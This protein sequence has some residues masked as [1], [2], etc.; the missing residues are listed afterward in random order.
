MK[1]KAV[2]LLLILSSTVFARPSFMQKKISVGSKKVV[3]EIADDEEKR[4][5]GLMKVTKLERDHG[6]LFI[7]ERE[8]PLSFWMKDTPI[9]LSIGFF[10]S[11]KMLVQI[12]EMKTAS[13]V[14]QNLPVYKSKVPCQYALEMPTGWYSAN[15]IKLG[16][17]LNI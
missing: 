8:R 14:Q 10:N 11:K 2:F 9:P 4:A 13:V 12:L 3:V 15:H 17:K 5:F 1:F 7:F 16:S 6:M